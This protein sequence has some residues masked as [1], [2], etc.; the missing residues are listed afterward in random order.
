MSI[1]KR[2]RDITVATLNERLEAAEDPVRMLD[3]YLAGMRDQL[4]QS[5]R[6]HQQCAIH[7]NSLRQ[8]YLNAL[9]IKEKR[10]SQAILALKAGEDNMARIILQE[11]MQA[12]ERCEQ[13]K[14]LYEQSKESLTEMEEQIAELR[15]DYEEAASKRSYYI[16]RMESARL[17]HRMN[18]RMN[19][20]GGNM[21]RVYDR[22]N[23]HV[24]DM[25]LEARSMRDLRRM[26][27]E[28]TYNSGYGQG[29][30]GL[31]QE[32]ENLRNKLKGE[33]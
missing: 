15:V 14:G 1:W 32:L 18:A 16:A 4:R 30:P 24:T 21:P 3:H 29:H 17:Q 31:E 7:A 23:E 33:E 22:I 12:E 19:T 9:E 5:E 8:Q 27:Q 6:L 11:K 28:G 10:E 2:M 26:T 13:F 25:E 20:M